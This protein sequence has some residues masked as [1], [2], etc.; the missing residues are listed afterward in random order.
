MQ[1]LR[2]TMGKAGIVKTEEELMEA[3]KVVNG[4]GEFNQPYKCR[5][6]EEYEFITSNHRT[7]Y[8]KC[9]AQRKRGDTIGDF[10][11]SDVACGSCLSK[12][13]EPCLC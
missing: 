7:Y 13:P 10:E 5:N 2:E 6:A 4:F 12:Q 8:K 3:L 11:T 9:S 1:Q